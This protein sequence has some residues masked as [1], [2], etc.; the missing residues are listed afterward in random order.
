L[1]EAIPIGEGFF[2]DWTDA[3][4]FNSLLFGISERRHLDILAPNGIHQSLKKTSIES[5]PECTKMSS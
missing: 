3:C 4:I 2:V 1:H 5:G